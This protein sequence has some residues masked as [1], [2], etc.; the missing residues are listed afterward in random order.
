MQK[1]FSNERF[2]SE[3]QV[4]IDLAK[5]AGLCIAHIRQHKEDLEIRQK[6]NN[7]HDVSLV[8]TADLQS[9]DIIC[10]GLQAHFPEYG[11]LSEET[12]QNTLPDKWWE[13]RYAWIID[14]L[15]GTEDF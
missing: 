1:R 6:K 5:K 12:D 14:P 3:L 9:N 15:D 7:D 4:S 8:T 13:K 2:S 10:K 11:I